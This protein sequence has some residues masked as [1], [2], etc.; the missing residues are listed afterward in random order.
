LIQ[1]KFKLIRLNEADY[2]ISYA[3]VHL[4]FRLLLFVN[5]LFFLVTVLSL[6]IPTY[7]ISKLSPVKS[8]RFN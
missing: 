4:D 5:L 8:I 3:P 6:L 2:Y 1:Q 7:Y